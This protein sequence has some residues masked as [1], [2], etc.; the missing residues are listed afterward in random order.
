M[1]DS[2]AGEHLNRL[3]QRYSFA[4][5]FCI[6]LV[7]WRPDLCVEVA[8]QPFHRQCAAGPERFHANALR[9]GQRP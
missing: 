9:I 1:K 2:G 8:S 7:P 4:A 6:P 3:F 5:A